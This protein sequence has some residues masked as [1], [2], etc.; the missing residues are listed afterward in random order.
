MVAA[1]AAVA[2]DQLLDCCRLF[3]LGGNGFSEWSFVMTNE[4]RVRKECEAEMKGYDRRMLKVFFKVVAFFL[5]VGV[6]SVLCLSGH[7]DKLRLALWLIYAGLVV[8]LAVLFGK[9]IGKCISQTLR[10]YRAKQ[11]DKKGQSA[12]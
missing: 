1:Y 9:V 7:P 12:A 11:A 5:V 10:I 6:A 2:G 8:S 3:G 4:E